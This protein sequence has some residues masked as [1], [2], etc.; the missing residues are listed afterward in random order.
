MLLKTKP[1]ANITALP[2]LFYHFCFSWYLCIK[3]VVLSV[4]SIYVSVCVCLKMRKSHYQTALSHMFFVRIHPKKAKQ[5]LLCALC[6]VRGFMFCTLLCDVSQITLKS[7]SNQASDWVWYWYSPLEVYF[8]RRLWKPRATG[9]SSHSGAQSPPKETF[10]VFVNCATIDHLCCFTEWPS[11]D[12]RREDRERWPILLCGHLHGGWSHQVS[13]LVCVNEIDP[14]C[15]YNSI[16][17]K[18]KKG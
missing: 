6:R 4:H 8:Y 10:H 17:E 12:Q 2:S 15:Y 1:G 14:F 11:P 5:R 13:S 18:Y 16:I 9:P 3:S 7:A